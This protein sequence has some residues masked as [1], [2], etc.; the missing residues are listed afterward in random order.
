METTVSPQQQP[1]NKEVSSFGYAL[2][3][4]VLLFD[5]FGTDTPDILYWSGK[6]LA[7]KYPQQTIEDIILFFNKASWGQLSLKKE[8]NST[9]H[10][11]LS[12]ELVKKRIMNHAT[13]SFQLEAGFLAEQIQLQKKCITEAFHCPKKRAAKVFITVQSDEKDR[14]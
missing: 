4:D 8:A 2:V 1:N 6:R 14:L 7:R 12:G 13:D 9:I 10:F 11:E 5:L 3:R